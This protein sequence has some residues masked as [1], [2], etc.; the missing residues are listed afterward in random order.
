MTNQTKDVSPKMTT[1]CCTSVYANNVDVVRSPN[2]PILTV[3]IVHFV[4]FVTGM[5]LAFHC[6]IQCSQL[7]VSGVGSRR[8]CCICII[9]QL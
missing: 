6:E 9:I 7:Q 3:F 8:N 4:C 5:R 1:R 2:P